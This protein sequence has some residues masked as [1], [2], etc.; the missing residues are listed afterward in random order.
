M[1]RHGAAWS[2]AGFR[3]GWLLRGQLKLA[4][5]EDRAL[6]GRQEG[7]PAHA[8]RIGDPGLL[9]VRVA[10]GGLADFLPGTF[11]LLQP[12]IDLLQLMVVLDLDAEMIEA[13]RPAA[14]RRDERVIPLPV[15]GTCA[16]GNR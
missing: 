1:P 12:S 7:F 6:A 13:P 10:A 8:L 11:G 4:G 16:S 14:V 3:L 2:A 9:R 15:P 5:A